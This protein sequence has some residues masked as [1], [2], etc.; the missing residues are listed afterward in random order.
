MEGWSMNFEVAISIAFKCW[1][2]KDMLFCLAVVATSILTMW[3]VV[4]YIPDQHKYPGAILFEDSLNA[5]IYI[6]SIHSCI[7][8]IIPPPGLCLLDLAFL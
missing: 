7:I 3:D 6:S 8:Y 2:V 1:F 4:E 5:H